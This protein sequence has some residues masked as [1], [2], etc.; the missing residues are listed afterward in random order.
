VVGAGIC[1]TDL[2]VV[3]A[4]TDEMLPIVLGHEGSGVVEQVGPDVS[5]LSPGDH[6]VLSY[7]YDGTCD[8][9]KA[10]IPMHCRQFLPMNLTGY[11]V[12]GSTPL[13]TNGAP[14][15]GSWFGQSSWATYAVANERNC[16]KVAKEL[17]L[18]L[19][20]PLGCGIQTGAGAVINSLAP[21]PG[22]SIAVFAVG[23]VGQAAILGARVSGCETII[24]V[25][26][27]DT[28]L[29]KARNIGATHTVNSTL[30]DAVEAIR[31]L[32]GGLG[33]HYTV[34]CIGIP[35]V[36]RSA[37]ESLQMPGTCVTVGYQGIPNEII[38]NQGDLLFGKTLR[39]VIEGDGVPGKFIPE[40]IA[41]YEDGRFPFDTMVEKFPFAD[42]NEAIDAVHHHNA[43]KAVLTFD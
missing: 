3:D 23:S 30:V 21:K 27:D 29:A 4:A 40:M 7:N 11:R 6:V 38:L 42:I 28:Q 36:V 37:V 1:H 24:A 10:N 22:S 39:G 5:S 43:T 20:G 25:D 32:T 19:L 41:L 17:P 33:A 15:L 35:D 8:N 26:V 14:V 12:D 16:I 31:D 13:S 34:D 9:C 18:E 2:G